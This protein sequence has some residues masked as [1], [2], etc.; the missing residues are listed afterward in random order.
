[1]KALAAPPRRLRVREDG[2][3]QIIEAAWRLARANGLAALTLR[4]LAQE[5]GMQ[6]PSLYSYFPS[7]HAIYDAMF[8]DGNRRVMRFAEGL[9]APHASDAWLKAALKAF[10]RF[11]RDDPALYQLLYQRSIPGFQPSSQ[12]LALSNSVLDGTRQLLAML[13]VKG[14][15]AVDLFTA[16]V[17]GL[18]SQ[19]TANDPKG[20]RWIRR[21]DD[22]VDMF[23]GHFRARA[24]RRVT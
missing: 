23:L 1:M 17:T 13:G 22:A 7:K 21:C 3:R 5:V 8:A 15:A 6:A 10:I 16:M 4:D 18:I 14:T 9:G 20:E 11:C 24:R 19:Q 2:R 12:S